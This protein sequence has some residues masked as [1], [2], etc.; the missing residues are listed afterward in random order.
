MAAFPCRGSMISL[1][2][3]TRRFCVG[4]MPDFHLLANKKGAPSSDISPVAAL[5]FLFS[6][7]CSRLIS[8]YL[9]FIIVGKRMN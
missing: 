9:D 4:K 8:A 2:G 3:A 5:L 7:F 1:C 6:M